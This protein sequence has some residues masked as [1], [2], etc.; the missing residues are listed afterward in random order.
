[1]TKNTK[2]RPSCIEKLKIETYLCI[3]RTRTRQPIKN[4]NIV[5]TM[6]STK[7]ISSLCAL[8]R[9]RACSG[10]LGRARACSG[11]LLTAPAY[12]FINPRP[13]TLKRLFAPSCTLLHPLATFPAFSL[14]YPFAPF[15]TLLGIQKSSFWVSFPGAGVGKTYDFGIPE[16]S[17]S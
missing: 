14:F 9:A 11:A 15:C 4:Y 17:N 2:K 5:I 8:G 12:V 10:V 16:R 7:F 3:G 6:L 1:M 13:Y